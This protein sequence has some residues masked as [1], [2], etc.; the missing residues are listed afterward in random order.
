MVDETLSWLDPQADDSV[1]YVAF[2]SRTAM[3]RDQMRELGMGLKRSGCGF[4][5][6]VKST[7]VDV[8]EKDGLED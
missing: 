7:I 4:L 6:V 8:E 2:G 1:I 5:R 3:S